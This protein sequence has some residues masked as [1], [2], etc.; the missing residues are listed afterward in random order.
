LHGRVGG[1]EDEDA[2]RH[3]AR[4]VDDRIAQVALRI[5]ALALSVRRG[6]LMP[7]GPLGEG[8][9][10]QL[11]LRVNDVRVLELVLKGQAQ[12]ISE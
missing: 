7:R 11:R 12:L 8:A 4:E 9:D 3:E 1:E 10:E 5:L 2:L 6:E